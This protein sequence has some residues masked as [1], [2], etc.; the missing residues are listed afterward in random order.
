MYVCVHECMFRL[1]TLMAFYL[2]VTGF[3]TAVR[4][5]ASDLIPEAPWVSLMH[6]PV[7]Y[8]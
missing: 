5:L 6:K 1:I 4:G 8:L 2:E 3:M 7:L